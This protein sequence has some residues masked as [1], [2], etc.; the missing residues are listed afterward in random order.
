MVVTGGD[1]N[2]AVAFEFVLHVYVNAPAAPSVIELFKQTLA[3]PVIETTGNGKALIV[4]A[5]V[6]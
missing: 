6:F 3:A 1:T 2:I 5:A 4:I